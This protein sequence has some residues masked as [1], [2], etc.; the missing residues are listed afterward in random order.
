MTERLTPESIQGRKMIDAMHVDYSRSS[1]AWIGNV[2]GIPRLSMAR[3]CDRGT[4]F[5]RWYVDTKPVRDLDCA[6]AV[7]NGDMTLEA[8]MQPDMKPAKKYSL[9]AQI[10][11]VRRELVQREKVYPR[12]IQSR[13]LKE[14]A[15]EY[16]T[17]TLKAV[18]ATLEWLQAN[19][20]DVRAF[21]GARVAARQQAA[22]PAEDAAA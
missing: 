2:E 1:S 11:E 8:A 20:A 6:C 3:G 19:E 9:D 5:I 17:D 7:I 15:A 4:Q 14:G 18:L 22:P 21:V 16:Q 12:L 13:K 10:T